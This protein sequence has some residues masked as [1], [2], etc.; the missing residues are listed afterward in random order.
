[1][2]YLRACINCAIDVIKAAAATSALI[3]WLNKF[4]FFLRFLI[5]FLLS[6]N[7]I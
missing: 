3:I 1:M 7:V 4:S 5:G 6:F 2:D